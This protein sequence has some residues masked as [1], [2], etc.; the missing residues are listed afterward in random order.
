[1][2]GRDVLGDAKKMGGDIISS[3]MGS[4]AAVALASLAVLV[5]GGVALGLHEYDKHKS[6]KNMDRI[7]KILE[8]HKEFLV[9]ISETGFDEHPS[10]P[11]PFVLDDNE[12]PSSASALKLNAAIRR[13]L[14][15]DKSINSDS[16]LIQ[17]GRHI[18]NAKMHILGF[19][20]ARL[21]PDERS[22]FT[23]GYDE[24]ITSNVLTY[25][26]IML[27]EHCTKFEGYQADMA[28]LGGLIKFIN[29]FASLPREG[30]LSS[31]DPRKRQRFERL[32]HACKELR[33]ARKLLI[34]HSNSRTLKSYVDELM[35]ASY[36]EFL[37]DLSN[38][39][40]KFI[41]PEKDWQHVDAAIP[42]L[43]ASGFVRPDYKNSHTIFHQSAI[44]IPDS[45]FKTWL[46]QITANY[47]D[48]EMSHLDPI[49]FKEEHLAH[50]KELFKV[51]Q[52]FLTLKSPQPLQDGSYAT[53]KFVPVGH[54]KECYLK[55]LTAL[56]PVFEPD[57]FLIIKEQTGWK[58]YEVNEKRQPVELKIEEVK[59]LQEALAALPVHKALERLSKKKTQ[60]VNWALTEYRNQREL[61]TRATIFLDLAVL[62]EQLADLNGFCQKLSDCI[63]DLGEIYITNPHH[64]NFIFDSL[65]AMGKDINN[66]I[67]SLLKAL[68]KVE[69]NQDLANDMLIRDQLAIATQLTDRLLVVRGRVGSNISGIIEKHNIHNNRWGNPTAAGKIDPTAYDRERR[70]KAIQEMLILVGKINAKYHIEID[71]Y[72]APPS[73]ELHLSHEALHIHTEEEA[74]REGGGLALG[75]PGLGLVPASHQPVN[76]TPLPITI[77]TEEKRVEEE[78]VG[79][80]S[81]AEELIDPDALLVGLRKRMDQ[82]KR[83]ENPDKKTQA[84]YEHLCDALNELDL[85]SKI[86]QKEKIP[87]RQTKAEAIKKLTHTLCKDTLEFLSHDKQKRGE[88]AADFRARI[89]D[90]LSATRNKFLDEHKDTVGKILNAVKELALCLV[91]GL[92]FYV[93]YKR[94][95]FFRTSSRALAHQV[96]ES[97]VSLSRKLALSS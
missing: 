24:D 61:K 10:L 38:L 7:K 53:D 89:S 37:P 72:Q 48:P 17:Y 44:A 43:I 66:R 87:G 33:K 22:G 30:A 59:G 6:K 5:V 67:G 27:S 57:V 88:E 85:K 35:S 8:L 55:I 62:L 60:A 96:E 83:E 56:P 46:Q 50:I 92:G 1:M 9:N 54:D 63:R 3:G 79:L 82:I 19:Y 28:Y 84:A 64:C 31:K 73:R 77:M 90:E 52:N 34:D 95:G 94:G 26:L 70:K 39:F 21:N 29:A 2:E 86:M 93:A 13:D 14:V 16:F 36:K 78:P 18:K 49:E 12:K 74:L 97:G 42:E 71:K 41:V 47:L 32:K 11:A 80:A 75:T 23:K 25:L 4:P 45:I 68:E 20:D 51:S 58:L 81:V 15:K 40:A 91:L 69:E 76:A 65:S